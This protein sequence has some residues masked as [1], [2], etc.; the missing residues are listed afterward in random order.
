MGGAGAGT[1]HVIFHSRYERVPMKFELNRAS[2]VRGQV[3]VNPDITLE[4]LQS[5]YDK[6]NLPKLDRPK[7]ESVIHSARSQLKKRWELESLDEVPRKSNGE[8]NVR[9]FIWMYFDMF[10]TDDITHEHVYHYLALDGIEVTKSNYSNASSVYKSKEPI[11][12]IISEDP[13]EETPRAG[14]PGK[15]KYTRRK[16]KGQGR[17]KREPL[18]VDEYEQIES[19][20]ERLL[21]KAEVLKDHKLAN[22]LRQARRQVGTVLV[23]A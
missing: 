2:F 7:T 3:L 5:A 16:A 11:T 13:E 19:V 14:K 17:Q 15:R 23:K 9:K 20:I 10:G 12:A 1:T 22:H 18:P 4:E 21:A 6:T 8:L